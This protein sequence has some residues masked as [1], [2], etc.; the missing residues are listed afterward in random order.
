MKH[1]DAKKHWI[2]YTL[3]VITLNIFFSNCSGDRIPFSEE[4]TNSLPTQ[5]DYNIHIKP[6]LSDRCFACHGPDKSNQKADLRL[7]TPEGAYAFLSS[8]AGKAIVPGSLNQSILWKRINQEN[9]KLIMPPPE[10]HLVLNDQEKALI[11][12]WIKQGAV[13]KDHW[14]FI[15]P[16]KPALPNI[17]SDQWVKNEIDHFIFKKAQE[18]GLKVS[19][20]ADKEDLIRR[21][22]FDLTGLPPTIEEIDR[23][24]ADD[25]EQSY[26]KLIDYYLKSPHYG[27]RMAVDWLDLAR[28]ADTHGY[29]VDRYRPSWQWRDWVVQAFNKNMPFDQ[30]ITW[31]IAGDM[32]PNASKEQILATGFNRNHPQ[33]AEGGIVNEEFRVEYVADRTNTLGSAL[34][35]LTLECAR[36]HDHKY[37]PISQK[38]YY[39]LFGFFNQID[40]S[41]QISYS[42]EAMPPPTLLLPDNAQEK[43]LAIIRA[44]IQDKQQVLNKLSKEQSDNIKK[45]ISSKAYQSELQTPSKNLIAHFTLDQFTQKYFANQASGSYRGEIVNPINLRSTSSQPVLLNGK[46]GKALQFNG[47]DALNFPELGRFSS[48]EPFS[49]GLWI[50]IPKNLE[51][52]VIFHSN[53]GAIIFNFK[54]YQVSL[55]KNRFDVRLANSFPYNAIHLLSRKNAPKNQ[56]FHLMLTYDGSS[57][58]K[59]VKLYLDG[60]PLALNIE[61]DNLYKDITFNDKE[62][63]PANLKVGARWRSKGLKNALID[64]IRV[65]QEQLSGLE[66]AHLAVTELP[67]FYIKSPQ[68]TPAVFEEFIHYFLKENNLSYRQRLDELTYLRKE[69][70]RVTEQVAEVMVMQEKAKARTTYLLERGAYDA[71]GEQVKPGTPENVLI[72][73]ANYPKNRIGLAKW[74][75]NPK[76]PLPARVIVNRIWQQFFGAGL[77]NTPDD[78]GNQGAMPTH[79]ALLDWLTVAFLESGWDIQ[80]LQKKILLSATYRQS[81]K[82]TPEIIQKDPYNVYLSRGPSLR[83]TAE[84]L[85]DNA[86]AASGLLVRKMGGP[87]VY[88][89]QPPGLWKMNSATYSQG[90]GEDLY[91][92]SL[93]TIWKRTVPPPS[94]NI[95]DAPTRSRCTAKR[96]QTNTPLQSLV[97]MNDPQFMEAAKMLAV[98]ILH[99][100]GNTP[101]DQI[102]YGFRLLCT[103]FPT[104][105]E[106]NLLEH[107]YQEQ[108]EVFKKIPTKATELLSIGESKVDN[109]LAPDKIASLGVVASTIMNLDAFIFKR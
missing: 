15:P 37:D 16:Q 27:E 104:D 28:Y 45:W 69:V 70:L 44:K 4:I 100:G 60:V 52:G 61:R 36:C 99:E 80:T 51:D 41:G 23:F 93:Y 94:M 22:S 57:K 101:R 31:Q 54:G 88:P 12:K 3:L 10:S 98:R 34:L 74:L 67:D 38:E 49:I 59:G 43:E 7:D 82:S 84:M 33:N 53:R 77:V 32:L 11:A 5:I 24:L 19:E 91:R 50:K 64:D 2:I 47:D 97:L 14:A 65:Y 102:Q 105:Y 72:F 109:T 103:R 89:Y 13:Y 21:L 73:P 58:A 8:G 9:P 85:R 66:V 18:Q 25:S 55:E 79:P 35:G 90:K 46:F 83:L 56:W 95:F 39:Q 42:T 107:L 30:F 106:L 78:F 26:E 20:L 92:R 108:I 48:A 6:I 96:Q 63:T 62:N 76:N 17:D 71:L 86:L 68:K 29:S 1:N 75:T 40:E 87:S 81:S